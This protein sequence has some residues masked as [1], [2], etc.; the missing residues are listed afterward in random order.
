MGALQLALKDARLA[1]VK[2]KRDDRTQVSAYVG[3]KG[4]IK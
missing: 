1:V 3:Y 2:M 4:E